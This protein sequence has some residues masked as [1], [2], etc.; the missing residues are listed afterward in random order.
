MLPPKSA[1]FCVIAC[2]LLLLP[3]CTS[4]GA[5]RWNERSKLC[6]QPRAEVPVWPASEFEAYAIELLGV[7]ADDRTKTRIERECRGS[8]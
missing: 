4:S 1:S 6:D 7:I 2:V 5:K 8:L 3:G